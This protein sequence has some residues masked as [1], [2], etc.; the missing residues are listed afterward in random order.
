M[1][2]TPHTGWA[3]EPGQPWQ[4]LCEA[5]TWGDCWVLLL[6]RLPHTACGEAICLPVGRHPDG[7]RKV[8]GNGESAS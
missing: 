4:V 7:R 3:R 5:P 8:K 1:M 2:N 6:A